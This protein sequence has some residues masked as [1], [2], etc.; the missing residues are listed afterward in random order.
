MPQLDEGDIIMQVEKLPS[1]SWH[2]P[3]PPTWRCSSAS[4]RPPEVERIVARV[5]R[6]SW[7]WTL[8][9]LNETDSFLVLKPRAEW[10]LPP[11]EA[12]ID[13]IREAA[14]GIPVLEPGLTSP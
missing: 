6:T 3:P 1:I 8:W 13:A 14:E 2:S 11:K 9:G 10:R 4:S 7:G 12:L 5:G